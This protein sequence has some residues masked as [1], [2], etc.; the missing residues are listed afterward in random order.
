M[1]FASIWNAMFHLRTCDKVATALCVQAAGA[2][3]SI[4]CKKFIS[5]SV[6]HILWGV[7]RYFLAFGNKYNNIFD[8]YDLNQEISEFFYIP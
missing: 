5:G 6:R 4:Q 1:K 2:C 3:Q 8:F 7:E